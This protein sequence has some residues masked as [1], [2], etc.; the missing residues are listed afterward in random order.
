[1]R[2][3]DPNKS[4]GTAPSS[5]PGITCPAKV[6]TVQNWYN[7]CAF[8]NPKASDITYT[9]T[10]YADSK[11]GTDFVPNTVAGAAA[12]AYVGSPRSQIYGPGYE[13]VDM[14]LFKS[15]RTF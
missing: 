10:K 14:S 7:P 3:G 13:R 11:S 2:I 9:T 6:R 1:I 5:N 8:A 15:F 4:G 12:L